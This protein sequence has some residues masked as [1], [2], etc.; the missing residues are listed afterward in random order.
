MHR[1]SPPAGG[2]LRKP[3]IDER[4]RPFLDSLAEMLAESIIGKN[5]SA[6]STSRNIN[7]PPSDQHQRPLTNAR[8]EDPRGFPGN[9]S[10]VHG[11]PDER[12]LVD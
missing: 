4:L 8:S 2:V 1:A 5:R 9:S 11:G 12:Q 10:S 7:S 3:I 6:N